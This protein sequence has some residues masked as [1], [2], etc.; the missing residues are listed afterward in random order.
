MA[1][2]LRESP[3]SIGTESLENSKSTESVVK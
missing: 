3:S 1:Q 2:V